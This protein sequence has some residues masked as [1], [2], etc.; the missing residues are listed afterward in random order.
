M[1]GRFVLP[2]SRLDEFNENARDFFSRD[3]KGAWRLSVLPSDDIYETIRIV[4]DF[5]AKNAPG[6]ICDSF[7]VKA[8]SQEEIVTLT[9]AIP[10]NFT[11]YFELPLTDNLPDLVSTL[12]LNKQCAKIRTGGIT[13]EVFPKT[14]DIVRFIRTCLAANIPFK[15]TAG[16]HHPI[17]CFKPL[18]Y[19]P[20]APKGT[21]HGFL[22]VFLAT[23][24][25]QEGYRPEL[26]EEVLE[27]EFEEVF[28]FDDNGVSWQKEYSLTNKQLITLR[29]KNIIS[30][31]SCSFDE[32][33]EDLQ[34]IGLL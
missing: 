16:L 5:N 27:E 32:P 3:G 14:K 6:A 20:N 11:N 24:F 19:E 22:N 29:E 12:A 30:F 31:G 10:D 26:L 18:S 4:E 7:E 34:E 23:G 25:A 21:M 17:R 13:P 28:V 33:I 9:N 2:V 8:T 1:L 15:A